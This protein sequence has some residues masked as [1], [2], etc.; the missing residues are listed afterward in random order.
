MRG[1]GP[2]TARLTLVDDENRALFRLARWTADDWSTIKINP[3]GA[4]QTERPNY[5][6][7]LYLDGI[8][9]PAG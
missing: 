1:G 8:H 3:N 9:F 6:Q 5:A 2:L 7:E 4:V